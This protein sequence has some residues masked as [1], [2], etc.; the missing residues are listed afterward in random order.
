[1]E[2]MS[3]AKLITGYALAYIMWLVSFFLWLWFMFLSREAISGLLTM[4]YLD[5]SLNKMKVFQFFNQ[6]YFYLTGLVWLIL[7]IVVENY[8]RQGV[9]KGDLFRR[10]GKVI[11]PELI[12]L[13]IANFA[14]SLVRIFTTVD[15][16]IL[17]VELV[18]G[19]ALIF[20]IVKTKPPR[21]GMLVRKES[22]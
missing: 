15:W 4:Y 10:I 6:W 11:A 8:L 7:M 3:K 19:A 12:L 14:R 17:I 20:W 13:A 1:M 2:R 5:G 9:V 22:A 18:L 16:L 21:P